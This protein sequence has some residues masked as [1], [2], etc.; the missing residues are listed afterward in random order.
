MSND[1]KEQA[2][3]QVE[4]FKEAA[5]QLETDDDEGRFN[6]R[7]GKVAKAPPPKDEKKDSRN[8]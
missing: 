2:P 5:R 3:S 1:R 8:G 7:L 6:E 4:K